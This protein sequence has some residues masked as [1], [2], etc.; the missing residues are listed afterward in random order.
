ML[1]VPLSIWGLKVDVNL[2]VHHGFVLRTPPACLGA[3][4]STCPM[5]LSSGLAAGIVDAMDMA[6]VRH[7]PMSSANANPLADKVVHADILVQGIEDRGSNG[8]VP[9]HVQTEEQSATARVEA[10]YVR[11]AQ[12]MQ[13]WW[14][15]G[16]AK[17][18]DLTDGYSKVAVLLI[19]W[20]DEID[21]LKT[22]KEVG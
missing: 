7:E 20:A 15:E 22:A 10:Q 1:L 18:M 9:Q 21:D 4:H 19:K 3:S 5:A 14:D 13:S 2:I 17:N 16:I 8:F 12:Q 6:V 11:E